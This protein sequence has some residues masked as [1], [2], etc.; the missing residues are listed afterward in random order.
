[1]TDTDVL[2]VSIDGT[3]GW[4]AAVRE[5]VAALTRAGA[6]VATAGTG[7]VPEV[8]TFALTDFVQARAA[9]RA[10]RRA[11]AEHDPK[12]II[13]CSITASLLWPRP[14][15][16]WLDSLAAE[17]RPGR[18]GIWQRRVERRRVARAPLVLAMSPRALDSV[19]RP[20]TSVIVLAEPVE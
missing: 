9:R 5:L 20:E 6:R 19:P 7:P 18:H 8:R 14:G 10:A 1:M 16:V 2:V 3:I 13:Y 15:V 4:G 11:L 17:N 12:A